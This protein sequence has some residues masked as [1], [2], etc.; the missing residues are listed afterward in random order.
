M[1]MKR[2]SVFISILVALVFILV[3]G[4][5]AVWQD[6]LLY[7]DI[8]NKLTYPAAAA[9]LQKQQVLEAVR[10][11]IELPQEEPTI[12]TISDKDKLADQRFFSQSQNGDI[13]LVFPQAQKAVLWRPSTRRVIN[14][15]P[16]V[17]DE[18]K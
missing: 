11:V 6:S 14:V 4:I 17:S 5:G 9:K 8:E 13:V 7:R 12:L 18:E 10:A 15:G 1:H 2:I 3:I 16:I